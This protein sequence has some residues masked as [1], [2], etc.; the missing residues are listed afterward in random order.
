M[1]SHYS[2]NKNK[3]CKY[4]SPLLSIAEM[5]RLYVKEHEGQVATPIIKYNYY[6]KIF[7]EEFNLS[8]GYPKSDTCGVCEQ[9]KIQLSESPEKSSVY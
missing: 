2:R 1:K 5:H 4:L 6:A 3:H 7:N 8:F 9:F